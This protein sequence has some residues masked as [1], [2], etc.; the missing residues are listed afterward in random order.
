MP[1]PNAPD[2]STELGGAATSAAARASGGVGAL[3]GLAVS[4]GSTGSDGAASADVFVGAGGS[5]A[6]IGFP[7]ADGSGTPTGSGPGRRRSRM[8]AG[9]AV[10]LLALAA[11]VT[12][13][14]VATQRIAGNPVTDWPKPPPVGSCVDTDGG[15]AVVPCS[16]PHDAEVTAAYGALD[17]IVTDTAR[18]PMYDACAASAA[19]YLG[20]GAEAAAIRGASGW[21]TMGLKYAAAPV[22]APPDQRAG[23]YGW[24]VCVVGPSVPARYLGSVRDVRFASA[25]AAFRT[26]RDGQGPDVS[27]AVP[28]RGEVLAVTGS[29]FDWTWSAGHPTAGPAGDPSEVEPEPPLSPS[30]PAGRAPSEGEQ[31]H[32]QQEAERQ[33]SLAR[34]AARQLIQRVHETLDRQCDSVAEELI[35]SGDATFGGLLN[36]SPTSMDGVDLPGAPPSDPPDDMSGRITV[37]LPSGELSPLAGVDAITVVLGPQACVVTATGD[38]RLT[39]SVIGWG[40]RPP[41]LTGG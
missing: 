40:H 11:L 6:P 3:R 5:D 7:A 19:D 20:P 23:A 39:G 24:Q 14:R 31:A 35:G 27:C 25:P 37:E 18:D 32:A 33:A 15:I 41:P 26:C 36:V 2:G 1:D 38:S 4:E 17:P 13:N 28:H 9:A 30:P 22:A 21:R 29:G 34:Q 16:G 8:L 12:V 10:L